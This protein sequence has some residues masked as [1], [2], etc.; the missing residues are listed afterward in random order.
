MAWLHLLCDCYYLCRTKLTCIII[1]VLFLFDYKIFVDN[2]ASLRCHKW[3]FNQWTPA[4]LKFIINH[5][6]NQPIY[7]QNVCVCVCVIKHKYHI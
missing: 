2:F 1:V 3:D 4:N 5:K 6:K 7:S